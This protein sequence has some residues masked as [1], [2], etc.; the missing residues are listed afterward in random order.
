MAR[1]SVVLV[2]DEAYAMPAAVAIRSLLDRS[3]PGAP[4]AAFFLLDA[5][6]S[7]TS[8]SRLEAITREAITWVPLQGGARIASMLP[9]RL[10]GGAPLATW[11]KVFL[12]QLLEG[13]GCGDVVLY[14][15]AD[16]MVADD[17]EALYRAAPPHL[18]GGVGA[19]VGGG[20]GGGSEAAVLAAAR[21]I[22]HP[23]G[24]AR[25]AELCAW[26]AAAGDAY[27]NAGVMLVS[28]RAMA[29]E[30]VQRALSAA[31]AAAAAPGAPPP[32]YA[33]QDVLNAALRGRWATLP[34]RWNVQGAGSYGERRVGVL[35][36]AAEWDELKA[37]PGAVHF[38]GPAEVAP[39][40]IKAVEH[41]QLL[42][43]KPWAFVSTHPHAAEFFR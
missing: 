40:A 27:F 43:T 16:V 38:T 30:G 19:G 21:D 9:P 8:R 35:F 13:V 4:P 42:G 32:L 12:P 20:D 26:D 37:A 3:P 33:D 10:R 31:L 11:G 5:G 15:D 41:G 34:Q 36:S 18:G 7:A 17:V 6:V 29:A 28:L 2:L 1:R 22:G 24:H 25:L 39:Y 14:L 23:A